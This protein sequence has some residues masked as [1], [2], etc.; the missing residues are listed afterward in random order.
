MNKIYSESYPLYISSDKMKNRKVFAQHMAVGFGDEAYSMPYMLLIYAAHGEGFYKIDNGEENSFTEGDILF[1]RPDTPYSVYTSPDLQGLSMYFA[2]FDERFFSSRLIPNKN[3]FSELLPFFNG[4][5]PY[6][7]TRDTQNR[8][9]RNFFV[10]ILDELFYNKPNYR[11]AVQ[12][13]LSVLL[14]DVFRLC[15]IGYYGE[16]QMYSSKT[17]CE[18]TYYINKK[19][20]TRLSLKETAQFLHVS[21]QYICRLFKRHFGTTYVNYVNKLRVDIIKSELENTDR[22]PFLICGDFELSDAYIK[23]I[24]KKYTGY[25]IKDYKN[26]FNYKSN[27]PL[28]K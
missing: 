6:L 19:I 28:Y 14:T 16:T 5:V 12:S 7:Y 11:M 22:P 21:P 3:E 24:F 27:N 1:L 10:K 26:K 13:L 23:N 9:I 2:V 18:V 15:S 8:E 20:Y 25:S 17:L 4:I